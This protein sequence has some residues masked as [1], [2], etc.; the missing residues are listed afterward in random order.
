M[1]IEQ[2]GSNSGR[3][4]VNL[5]KSNLFKVSSGCTIFQYELKETSEKAFP[6]NEKFRELIMKEV[7]KGAADNLLN[8]IVDLE[9]KLFFAVKMLNPMKLAFS[10]AGQQ[11]DIE[12][13]LMGTIET[14]KTSFGFYRALFSSILYKSQLLEIDDFHVNP[15]DISEL[16]ELSLF[17]AFKF[18]FIKLDSQQYISISNEMLFSPKI[19]LLQLLG[20]LESKNLTQSHINRIFSGKLVQTKY[21]SWA[22]YLKITK[23]NFDLKLSETYITKYG[24]RVRLLDYFRHKYPFLEIQNED[25]PVF[26][27]V[28]INNRFET[29]KEQTERLLI[30]ETLQWI[31]TNE[32]MEDVHGV[33]YYDASHV[34]KRSMK[35]FNI[36]KFLNSLIDKPDIKNELFRWRI[37]IEK[38]SLN[39]GFHPFEF[40]PSLLMIGPKGTEKIER[41]LTNQVDRLY[42]KLLENRL[43]NFVPFQEIIIMAPKSLLSKAQKMSVE[44]N[45]CLKH[46]K[47]SSNLVDMRMVE[48][49]KFNSW[50]Q[51]IESLPPSTSAGKRILL[52]LT[53]DSD[54]EP[55]VR[56]YLF[57]KNEIF[58]FELMSLADEFH[59]DC[60]KAHHLLMLLNQLQ[61]GQPWILNELNEQNPIVV[62]GLTFHQMTNNKCLVTYSFS[63]N[64]HFT[65]YISKMIILEDI[66][67]DGA[68]QELKSFFEKCSKT[69]L[70]KQNLTTLDYSGMI[71]VHFLE[72]PKLFS[73]FDKNQNFLDSQAKE[74]AHE[75]VLE[76]YKA[77]IDSFGQKS[78]VSVELNPR[79]DLSLFPSSTGT[80]RMEKTNI[81]YY[82]DFAQYRESRGYLHGTFPDCLQMIFAE[83]NRFL[84]VSKYS[85]QT[86]QGVLRV[87]REPS[88]ME[89]QIF[90][91]Q[92]VK[93]EH[94]KKWVVTNTILY[95]CVDF[96]N[97]DKYVALPVCLK[98]SLNSVCKLGKSVE[99]ITDEKVLAFNK[100]V[101][102]AQLT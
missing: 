95:G 13:K 82:S 30:P 1:N 71:F 32:D 101:G 48:E 11:Y 67:S 86:Q 70:A 74:A 99:N 62:G 46:F 50:Q 65:K 21:P 16:E 14:L 19:N 64:K 90:H 98:M 8:K 49:D 76:L 54:L 40:S 22:K 92:Q 24:E 73:S 96:E 59:F 4:K 57:S 3:S 77:S 78:L 7:N 55:E 26:S 10:F 33:N 38:A 45:S 23:I 47:Y 18:E 81:E 56:S 9:N 34:N 102:Q 75:K 28:P 68:T 91:C 83:S 31:I 85:H 94:V 84:L 6:F 29:I 63:W 100:Y 61:G 72:K 20:T 93:E 25:Q 69:M 89:Y 53:G 39:L 66:Y 44:F 27:A 97:P 42:K 60:F 52:C 5:I 17:P 2:Q 37:V 79:K 35:Y 41:D 87:L 36:H 58:R 88:I 43:Y 51:A 12:M 15:F 80:D